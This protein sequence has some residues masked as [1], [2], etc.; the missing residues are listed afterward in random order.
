[1]VCDFPKLISVDL[2]LETGLQKS[3]FRAVVL[4]CH[5]YSS[6][7]SHKTALLLFHAGRVDSKSLCRQGKEEAVEEKPSWHP[8]ED[9]WLGRC[10]AVCGHRWALG[11]PEHRSSC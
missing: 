2:R 6:S 11:E 9:T 7:S 8:D 1:M 4:K 5:F 3:T 10:G